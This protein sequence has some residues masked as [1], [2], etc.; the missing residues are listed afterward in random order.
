MPVFRCWCPCPE[1][2]AKN[3]VGKN[4]TQC[5]KGGAQ[6]GKFHDFEVAY[7]AV[8]NHL[9]SSPY[10]N[11]SHNDAVT[12]TAGRDDVIVEDNDDVASQ[13]AEGYHSVFE[14]RLCLVVAESNSVSPR[15]SIEVNVHRLPYVRG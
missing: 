15:I 14:R 6:L 4:V 11:L 12:I 2:V 10:H 1:N 7:D 13:Q 9:K 5:S 3:T 8:I